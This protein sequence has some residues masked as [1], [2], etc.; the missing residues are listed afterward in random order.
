MPDL[1]Q[2]IRDLQR[3]A[4]KTST[5]DLFSS[6]ADDMVSLE[7]RVRCLEQATRNRVSVPDGETAYIEAFVDLMS[8]LISM[9]VAVTELSL[10]REAT[11]SFDEEP[12]AV[13]GISPN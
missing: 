1:S 6:M 12:G 9:A 10:A 8:S 3:E 7:D 2:N 4:A 13:P 11:W 5:F